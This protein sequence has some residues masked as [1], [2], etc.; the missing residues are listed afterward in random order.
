MHGFPVNNQNSNLRNEESEIKSALEI[1][2]QLI[3]IYQE[4]CLTRDEGNDTGR[5]NRSETQT[6]EE[7]ND[8]YTSFDSK[9]VQSD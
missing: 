7:M 3:I 8:I 5:Q 2:S 9:G 4:D 1:K 6:V